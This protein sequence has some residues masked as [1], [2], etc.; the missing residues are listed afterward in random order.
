MSRKPLEICT[1]D[2][3][4]EARALL[5]DG[6]ERIVT[7]LNP[8]TLRRRAAMVQAG[9]FDFD[10][11]LAVGSQWSHVKAMIP[12]ALRDEDN[13]DLRWYLEWA[14]EERV[15]HDSLDDRN[16]FMGNGDHM[17]GAAIEGAWISR[18]IQ[19]F[20]DAGM[21]RANF[22]EAGNK[23]QLR[24]GAVELFRQIPLRVIIS[25]GLEQVIRA[26]IDRYLLSSA[27]AA[28]RLNFGCDGRL[29]GYHPNVVVSKTKKVALNRFMRLNGL[30]AE[31][32]LIIGDSY[33]DI[34]MMPEHSFNVWILPHTEEVEGIAEFRE[35]RFESML[36]RVTMVLYSNSLEP[37]ARLLHEAKHSTSV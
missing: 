20:I 9:A 10:G 28:T 35:A 31:N 12:E 24:K 19:R 27:I 32:H 13:A 36:R 1:F 7:Q 8:S 5:S 4:E 23:V 34:E 3:L 11:S 29:V 18:S 16:W 6:K 37:L 33:I 2:T 15:V 21:T 30:K 26:C 25:M 17:N 22:E 14:K